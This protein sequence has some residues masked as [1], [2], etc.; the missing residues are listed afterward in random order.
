MTNKNQ[1]GVLSV[2]KVKVFKEVKGQLEPIKL[3]DLGISHTGLKKLLAYA[4]LGAR[5]LHVRLNTWSSIE[6][7]LV[8]DHPNYKLVDVNFMFKD[9]ATHRVLGIKVVK[10][11][12]ISFQSVSI[13]ALP[14][15]AEQ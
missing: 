7:D 8:E 15:K 6:I 3:T 10:D 14:A 12:A 1:A 11:N 2:E 9:Y 13:H 4:L 5:G